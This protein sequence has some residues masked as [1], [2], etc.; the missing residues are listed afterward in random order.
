MHYDL[1]FINLE[2]KTLQPLDNSFGTAETSFAA[3]SAACAAATS[4]CRINTCAL[5]PW[6]KAK[7]GS[8]AMARS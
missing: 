8:A 7:P 5:P 2:Q 3:A 6:A 1:G 4:P